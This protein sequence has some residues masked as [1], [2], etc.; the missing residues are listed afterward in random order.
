MGLTRRI[1]GQGAPGAHNAT[2]SGRGCM[3]QP[4]IP[5]VRWVGILDPGPHRDYPEH[6]F[7][8]TP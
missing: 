8:I 5:V 2:D 4:Q 1:Q 7:R 6:G 3:D